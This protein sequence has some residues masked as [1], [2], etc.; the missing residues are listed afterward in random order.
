MSQKHAKNTK[1]KF[2][3]ALLA[4]NVQIC[5]KYVKYWKYVIFLKNGKYDI[6]TY[7]HIF[8]ESSLFY[9]VSFWFQNHGCGKQRSFEKILDD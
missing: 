7:S 3:L 8:V 9:F 1:K 6:F 2:W 5:R 4:K